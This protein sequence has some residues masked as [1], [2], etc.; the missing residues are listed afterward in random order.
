MEALSRPSSGTHHPTMMELQ[1]GQL[2]SMRSGDTGATAAYRLAIF[3][4]LEE[5]QAD[6]F[7]QAA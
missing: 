2:E 5:A 4:K 3:L 6:A 7:K 1:R